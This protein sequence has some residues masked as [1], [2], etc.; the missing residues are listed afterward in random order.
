MPKKYCCKRATKATLAMRYYLKIAHRCL[1]SFSYKTT[2]KAVAQ[3]N[4]FTPQK[5]AGHIYFSVKK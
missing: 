1:V 4:G 3:S 2:V 5:R